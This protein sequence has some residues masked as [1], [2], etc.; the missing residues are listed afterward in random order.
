MQK[1]HVAFLFFEV[2]ELFMLTYKETETNDK[3]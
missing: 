2:G 1:A 3:C